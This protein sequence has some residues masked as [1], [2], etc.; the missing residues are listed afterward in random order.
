MK[1]INH[2]LCRCKA[3]RSW[4]HRKDAYRQSKRKEWIKKIRQLKQKPI[5]ERDNEQNPMT[6]EKYTD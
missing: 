3:C 4:W 1:H 5:E 2:Y 6:I